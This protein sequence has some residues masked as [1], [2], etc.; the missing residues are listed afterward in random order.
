MITIQK[1]QEED[2]RGVQ[3][4][5]YKTWLSTYPN[6]EAGITKEDIEERFKNHFSEEFVNKVKKASLNV[7]EN[8]LYLIAKDGMSVVGVC[9]AIKKENFNQLQSIYVLPE[10][11]GRGIGGMF[12]K[13][14]KEFFNN[15][16]DIIIQ[17]A[18]YN[19]QAISFYEK[20]GFVDNGKRLA[21]ERF[22]MPISG[23]LIPEMEMV[24]KFK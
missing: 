14:I 8:E 20:L 15:G 1:P 7:P 16:E 23:A 10:Y 17:V 18:T 13:E 2:I 9:R 24:L 21:D 22:K 11:Q 4:V 5:Y 3:E 6:K 12:W 19:K